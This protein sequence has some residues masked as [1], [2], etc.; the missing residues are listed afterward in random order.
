[1]NDSWNESA[2][3]E[4]VLERLRDSLRR[5]A[6]G[7]RYERES[8]IAHGGMGVIWQVRDQRM[9]RVLAMK[10]LRTPGSES[11][12]DSSFHSKSSARFLEEAQVT[13]QLDHP[14]IVPVHEVGLDENDQLFFTMRLV[15]G[16]T[17]DEVFDA[18]QGGDDEWSLTRALGVL[19]KVCEAMAYA[20]DHGV[21]HRDLK[22]ANIMVGR[23]GETYVM[24]WGLAKILGREELARPKKREA[25]Q[26]TILTSARSV[27]SSGDTGSALSTMDGDVIG[28]PAYMAPEQ[29][30]GDMATIGPLSDVYAVGALLYH[31]LAG[32]P[33]YLE[34]GVE[35]SP[36]DV[37]QL[38]MERAPKAL[39][40]SAPSE[41]VAICDK[42]MA[43]APEER[44]PSM[45]ALSEDLRAF[46]EGRVVAA[47]E[48]GAVAEFTKWVSRNKGLAAS[49]LLALV[50]GFGGLAG[51]LL[52]Q[53][54]ANEEL[55][56]KNDTLS[57]TNEALDLARSEALENEQ[58]ALEK[59]REAVWQSY[60][61]NILAAGASIEMGA[62][63]NAVELL[64]ACA[65]EHRG[66]E[67]NLF[68]NQVDSS[69]SRTVASEESFV[70]TVAYGPLGDVV[71]SGTGSF[72]DTGGDDY[73]VRL[74][75][76]SDGSPIRDFVGHG[77]N[78]NGLTFSPS[79]TELV[80]CS[81]DG[82]VRV[83]DV[84]SGDLVARASEP[85]AD[86]AFHPTEFVIAIAGNGRLGIWEVVEDAFDWVRIGQATS[87]DFSEDGRYLAAG[88]QDAQVVMIDLS[89]RGDPAL[90]WV[91]VKAFA[92]DPAD[93]V[94]DVAF[95]AGARLAAALSTGVTLLID[96]ETGTIERAL[97][98][99]LD[100][101]RGVAFSP[102]G[103]VLS[104]C[105]DDG[106]IRLWD[107]ESGTLL[108]T[109]QGHDDEVRAIAMSPNG[110]RLVSG[111]KDGSIRLWDGRPGS[112]VTTLL[113]AGE[114]NFVGYEAAFAP[115]GDRVAWVSD[116]RTWTISDARTGEDLC[117]LPSL[118]VS[119][120]GAR[121]SDDG[122]Q[123]VTAAS[124]DHLRTWDAD[125]GALLSISANRLPTCGPVIFSP[126][127][128]LAI[129]TVVGGTVLIDLATGSERARWEMPPSIYE[130]FS[131]DGSLVT[132]SS[133]DGHVHV[134]DT[135]TTE[136]VVRI[137]TGG[138]ALSTAFDPEAKHLF[139]TLF[140]AR[141][142][143]IWMYELGTG[144]PVRELRG[145]AQPGLVTFLPDAG[146]QPR[147][148]SGNWD[149]TLSLWDPVR[150]E[151]AAISA[152][153]GTVFALVPDPTGRRV[154]TSENGGVYRIW[155]TTSAAERADVRLG[156]AR[157]ATLR[158]QVEPLVDSLMEELVLKED[159]RARIAASDLADDEEQAAL[160]LVSSATFLIDPSREAPLEAPV[161]RAFALCADPDGTPDE[162]LRALRIMEYLVSI[163][164]HAKDTPLGW[165]LTF[166]K[167]R[168][169]RVD[170]ALGEL[171]AARGRME[172]ENSFQ[173]G[174]IDVLTALCQIERGELEEARNLAGRWRRALPQ[175]NAGTD[176]LE[177]TLKMSLEFLLDEAEGK[178]GD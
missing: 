149:G 31:L 41:L 44:Y 109:L 164:I 116:S 173:T 55:A 176:F 2:G 118:S 127:G 117:R 35:R 13:G 122:T 84:E 19:H 22:P 18:V 147:L 101:V 136:L 86:V 24:D 110:H 107:V 90:T 32:H 97:S 20:H 62:A 4:E 37:L 100:A 144:E 155:D 36:I 40:S 113:G 34:P 1:M 104:T 96:V 150:G 63:R 53:S 52:V 154:L 172:K 168:M 91:D 146:G 134:Y 94:E 171:R 153:E 112:S 57:K 5:S 137:E 177:S 16:R 73:R 120:R 51:V 77:A 50:L 81:G 75:R 125:S 7:E 26:Q 105:S 133:S 169:G 129:T 79:G 61:A 46:L 42:A 178:L 49:L 139:V 151:I 148:A 6:P 10:V 89:K 76:A 67:W 98:G 69:L 48:T 27:E 163:D 43:R 29:A 152:H 145:H 167:L 111:S 128:D 38:A 23:F 123:L 80:S 119:P 66:W 174:V 39:P 11:S 21:L 124:G 140:D 25:A 156:A 161:S 74:Y 68:Q 60:V 93:S 12:Y 143:T 59:E 157:R 83:W 82:S 114:N 92:S 17:L 175:I 65:P 138:M 142:D 87:V 45:F 170:E 159:V 30:R 165:I 64:D 54:R 56:G 33:P 115:E 162:Y 3:P 8:E 72:G 88:M 135:S 14:G 85:S 99:H 106:S 78:V 47:Y 130:S 160:R 132:A 103:R 9:R 58:R 166:A 121:F 70:Y 71:A 28:T 131:A 158:R 15:K 102:D 126:R 95:G 141:D 108:E